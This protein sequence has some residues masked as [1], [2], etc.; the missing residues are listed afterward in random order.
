MAF[1]HKKTSELFVLSEK[2][3]LNLREIT[4]NRVYGIETKNEAVL[5]LV[6]NERTFIGNLPKN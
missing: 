2:L 6:T 5:R 3:S 1:V 4:D